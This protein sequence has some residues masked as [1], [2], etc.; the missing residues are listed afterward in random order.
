MTKVN[1]NLELKAAINDYCQKKG[2]SKNELSIQLGINGA[3]LSKIE[4]E[5]FDEIT[6]EVLTKVW[7]AIKLRTITGIIE[8]ADFNSVLLQCEKT[9]KHKL[10]TGMIA[11]TGMGKTTSLRAYSMRENVFFVQ[12]DKTMNAKRLFVAILREMQILFDGNIHDI[13]LKIAEELNRIDSP[14]LILDE[15]GK[16]NHSMIL[17]LHDLREHTKANCGILLSGMPY[18]KMNLQ[19]FS[20]KQKEGYSEFLRRVN[21]W[22]ELKGLSRKEIEFICLQYGI[23]GECKAYYGLRFGDLMNRILLEQITTD[24]N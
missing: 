24:K 3:Y 1:K 7:S 9:R 19:K 14:L 6:P 12:V 8:T 13:M 10:M 21:I 15:A 2:I 22:H 18:F 5:K 4:N 16:L 20:N 17:Y 11:D 23:S